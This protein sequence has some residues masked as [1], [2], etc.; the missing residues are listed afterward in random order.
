[1]GDPAS[2]IGGVA[3]TISS[4]ISLISFIN[5]IKNTPTDVK[6]C[7]ALTHRVNTDLEHLILLR[8]QHHKYLRE[9]P[10]SASRIDGIVSSAKISILD[11]CQVL[12]GCRKEI[13]EDG[14]IPL[15]R[16]MSWVLGDSA[17]FTR[18][19][20]NLQQQ[21]AA[22]NTEIMF[23]RQLS[24]LKPLERTVTTTFENVHLLSMRERRRRER[25]GSVAGSG[26]SGA[27]SPTAESFVSIDTNSVVE[28]CKDNERIVE[29][30]P[31]LPQLQEGDGPR[32]QEFSSR[33]K[34]PSYAQMMK[35][36]AIKRKALRNLSERPVE[37]E[38]NRSAVEERER[39]DEEE[40]EDD[41]EAEYY[42]DLRRQEEERR[43]RL[44]AKKA[45]RK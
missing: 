43:K 41:L 38:E 6:T 22:I 45:Q 21:H 24:V 3:G 25:G 37:E 26:G 19:S 42:R 33:A 16:K 23:L 35:S 18:R 44:A 5:N 7:F 28:N 40:N 34:S 2:M 27:L 10:T 29:V 17:A 13:Y 12:E 32:V 20:L 1:M 14:S 36:N 39:V 11:I 4:S 9:D 8:N 30:V 15:R 31:P